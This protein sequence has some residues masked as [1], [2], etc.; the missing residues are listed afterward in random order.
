MDS[1]ATLPLLP[2]EIAQHPDLDFTC[3]HCATKLQMELGDAYRTLAGYSNMTR[4]PEQRAAQMDEQWLRVR[5]PECDTKFDVGINAVVT[6]TFS[7]VSAPADPLARMFD[8]GR[9]FN[10]RRS[11]REVPT[12]R[13]PRPQ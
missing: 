2:P 9:L 4:T 13:L 5:C 11:T 3:P 1:S 8:G 7:A 6:V 12:V 10:S